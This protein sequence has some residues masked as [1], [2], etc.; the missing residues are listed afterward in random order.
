MSRIQ[1]FARAAASV[2]L[3][4]PLLSAC[5]APGGT[6]RVNWTDPE[7]PFFSAAPPRSETAPDT[8]PAA[9]G[10]S[11][12]P[13]TPARRSGQRVTLTGVGVNAV[14]EACRLSRDTEAFS[15]EGESH[16]VVL[17][18]QWTT[19]SAWIVSVSS[20]RALTPDTSLWGRV[21]AQDVVCGPETPTVLFD[22]VPARLYDCRL[23]RGGWSMVALSAQTGGTAYV[24]RGI[25]AAV[26]PVETAIGILSDRIRT[27]DDDGGAGTG[28]RS[29]AIARLEAQLGNRLFNA[30]D[31]TAYEQLM[32]VAAYYMS[33][34]NYATAEQNYQEA[35]AILRRGM[36]PSDPAFADPM[37][38]LGLAL[39]SQGKYRDA[40]TLFDSAEGLAAADIDELSAARL[41]MYRAQHL[42][43][44]KDCPG[45]QGQLD[46]AERM[47]IDLINKDGGGREVV[48]LSGSRAGAAVEL[49]LNR[50]LQAAIHLC[51]NQLDQAEREIDI[52]LREL[53]QFE[54]VPPEWRPHFRSLKAEVFRRREAYGGSQAFLNAA[55]RERRESYDPARPE[56]L[57]HLYLGQIYALEGEDDKAV[58]AYRTGLEIMVENNNGV[59]LDQVLPFLKIL[60]RR[61]QRAGTSTAEDLYAEM[62][63]TGQVVRG[64]VTSQTISQTTARL[65][66]GD[67]AVAGII[68]DYLETRRRINELNLAIDRAQS[69][70][71]ANLRRAEITAMASERERLREERLSIEGQVQAAAPNFYQLTMRPVALDQV[72]ASLGPEEAILQVLLGTEESVAFIVTADGVRPV[73]QNIGAFEAAHA[74]RVLRQGVEIST[75]NRLG[76]FDLDMANALYEAYVAPFEADLQGKSHLVVVP[77]GPL[78]SLPFGL[79]VREPARAPGGDYRGV[80]WLARDFAVSTVPSVRNLVDLRGYDDSVVTGSIAPNPFVGFGDFRM[81]ETDPGPVRTDSCIERLKW[82]VHNAPPLPE[83]GEELRDVSAVFGSAGASL[84]LGPRFTEA[85]VRSARLDAY[86]VVY[87]A[88]HGLMPAD[89]GCRTE[90]ALVTSANPSS[91]EETDDGLLLLSEILGLKLDADLVVL[92]ACNTGGGNGTGGESLSGLARGFFYTGARAML[93]SHWYVESAAARDLMVETFRAL[94][95][96]PDQGIAEAIR[97]ARMAVL[98]SSTGLRAGD[99]SHPAFWAG[100]TLVGDG[101]RT[102]G[103]LRAE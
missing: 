71:D 40:E 59:S 35:L 30:G 79:L 8:G 68:R 80:P 12:L 44:Q 1:R 95:R 65:A 34:G 90:P 87:F 49:A 72:L 86:Q 77:S 89:A 46:R 62:F 93:V 61:A 42:A 98:N 16:Y 17:C 7:D 100:F 14:G 4:L 36:E 33:I 102:V 9:D 70:P 101:R 47:L 26:G 23:K 13:D 18:G 63:A 41:V 10:P 32:K 6:V 28:E 52:A 91:T 27:D 11:V 99:R 56:A 94:D 39:S 58:R 67:E 64:S 43:H 51:L 37:M 2:L 76:E 53:N 45:A 69:R 50:A 60:N 57:D 29:R 96:R 92:S 85:A 38:R 97:T 20:D 25:P 73:F 3:A 22:E 83:T 31:I 82:M 66:S 5:A 81:P 103:A 74:V 78:L 19:P 15:E 21:V 84:R 24:A 55:I 48:I 75:E 88:T 54:V